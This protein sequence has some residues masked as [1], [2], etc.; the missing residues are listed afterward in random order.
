[1]LEAS[2]CAVAMMGISGEKANA[3]CEQH[4]LGTSSMRTRLIDL[5]GTETVETFKQ[6]IKVEKYTLD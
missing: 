6:A 5:M 2:V 4:A 3:Y 1:M